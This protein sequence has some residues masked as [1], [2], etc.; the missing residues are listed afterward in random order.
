MRRGPAPGHDPVARAATTPLAVKT[1]HDMLATMNSREAQVIALHFGLT[2]GQARTL[3]EIGQMYGVTPERVSQIVSRGVSMLRHPLRSQALR[4]LVDEGGLSAAVT[5]F[6]RGSVEGQRPLLRCPRH[7]WID[8]DGVPPASQWHAL[9]RM[10][11]FCSMCPCPLPFTGSRPARHCDSACRQAAHRFQ[12]K[13]PRIALSPAQVETAA[14]L[15]AEGGTVDLIARSL[16]VSP[17]TL[18]RYLATTT[19]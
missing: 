18:R 16:A 5:T 7:G 10:P 6:L 4:G 3:D 13:C 19:T 12:L 8:P 11:K 2:D 15:R 17:S 1:L 9:T 14:R